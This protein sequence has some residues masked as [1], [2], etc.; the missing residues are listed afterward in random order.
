MELGRGVA[1]ERIKITPLITDVWLSGRCCEID[2]YTRMR[3]R[4]KRGYAVCVVVW[5]LNN[6]RGVAGLACSVKMNAANLASAPQGSVAP[7]CVTVCQIFSNISFY[8]HVVCVAIT[9]FYK[10]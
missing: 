6:F 2:R 7:I 5:V 9:F 4:E 8:D 3:E 10:Q 1:A